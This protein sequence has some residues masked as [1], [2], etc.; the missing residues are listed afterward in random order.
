MAHHDAQN[1]QTAAAT[2]WTWKKLLKDLLILYWIVV[3]SMWL[4]DILVPSSEQLHEQPL[5]NA[6]DQQSSTKNSPHT[7]LVEIRAHLPFPKHTAAK[8][9][10]RFEVS[11][12]P[13]ARSVSI[14][15]SCWA[16]GVV[17][18]HNF[19]HLRTENQ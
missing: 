2:K 17:S 11:P 7:H 13:C 4:V 9:L 15:G 10:F 8:P 16:A 12:I 5:Q 19:S 14:F 1:E 18:H 3:G 6:V